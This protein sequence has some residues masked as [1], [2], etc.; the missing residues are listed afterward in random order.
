MLKL[1]PKYGNSRPSP[2]KKIRWL[3]FLIIVVA[4]LAGLLD[5]PLYWNKGADWINPK[6]DKL[7]PLAYINVPHYLDFPFKQGLDLVGGTHLI[8]EADLSEIEGDERGPAMEGVRDVIER[9]VNVFGV[10]EPDI[11]IAGKN[12]DRLNVELAGI[13]DVSE[14][15]TMIGETPTLEFKVLNEEL[16]EL[17]PEQQQLMD[18]ENVKIKV[19]ADEALAKAVEPEADFVSLVQEYSEDLPSLQEDG[20]IENVMSE[21]ASKEAF[22]QVS[23]LEVGQVKPDLYENDFGYYI[24]KL[25]EKKQ[26]KMVKAS[27]LLICHEEAGNCEQGYTKDEARSK[28]GELKGQATAENFAD[29]ARDNSTGPSADKGGDLDWFSRG[30]MVKPFEEAVFPMGVSEISDVVE[31]DFGFHLIHKTDEKDAD[32]LS[33]RQIMLRKKTNYDYVKPA[34][35]WKNTGLSGKQL[36]KA[37]L[38]YDQY[39]NEPYVTLEFNDEGSDLLEKITEENITKPMAIL[40]DGQ[41]IIDTNDDGKVDDQDMYAPTIQDKISG[42]RAQITGIANIVE[43]QVLVRRL[44]TGAL[45]VPIALISQQTVGASLGHDSVQKSLGAALIGFIL[46]AVFMLLVYRLPGLLAIL[47]LFVYGLVVL[48]ILKLFGV[49]LTLAGIA[50]FILSIG[51]AVDAN[52]L[53]FERL[54]E[55]L[56][57]GKT[58]GAAVDE[59][60]N[61]AWPSIR[62]GN[63]STIITCIILIMFTTSLVK[64]FAITLLI[65]V[66]LSMVSAIFVTKTFLRLVLPWVKGGWILGGDRKKP[67]VEDVN[68]TNA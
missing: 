48:A 55:E 41:S 26:D 24:L 33:I 47:A 13:K 28:I 1:A 63:I 38:A 35:P 54:K 11:R 53:I 57:L 46:V 37:S 44:N 27:H 23:G 61:R 60:F 68:N 2:R 67:V 18:S 20:L 66:I 22:E 29:L 52:V 31:T 30:A 8:Y 16:P 15:I 14:A 9:R 3:V 21:G 51:M 42:G 4:I 17:T 43:A 10:A 19:K 12:S 45:P 40:L 36:N 25:E 5:Y 58:F 62:D 39:T 34:D 56:R 64:G 50:G 49:T 65:G 6:L 7:G 59:G 32:S